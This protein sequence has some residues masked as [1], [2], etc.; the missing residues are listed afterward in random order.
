MAPA[1]VPATTPMPKPAATRGSVTSD[2]ALQFAGLRRARR[3]SRRS[4]TAA[5]PAGRWRGPSRTAIS[6]TSAAATGSIRPSAGRRPARQRVRV[7]ALFRRRRV[8]RQ[9]HGRKGHTNTR[10][11][12]KSAAARRRPSVASGRERSQAAMRQSRST[13]HQFVNATWSSISSS[14]A[15][16]TSTSALMTPAFC[17]AMPACRI[18]SRCVGPILL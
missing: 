1:S 17:N 15:F 16:F 5:A 8:R 10:A 13:R 14:T 11:R 3:R 4:P 9:C 7:A 2:M 18:E 12:R 6:Q